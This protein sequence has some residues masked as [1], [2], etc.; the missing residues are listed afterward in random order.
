MRG[1]QAVCV[2][3][4]ICLCVCTRLCVCV[5]VRVRVRVCVSLYLAVQLPVQLADALSQLGQLLSDDGMVDDLGRVR[6]H[7]K[8]VGQEVHV[9]LCKQGGSGE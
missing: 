6:L 5:R 1:C 7:V 2:C 3:V 8:V 9:A 4:Y